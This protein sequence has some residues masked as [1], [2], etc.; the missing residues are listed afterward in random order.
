MSINIDQIYLENFEESKDGIKREK[1][2]NK[3]DH[4]GDTMEISPKKNKIQ[5]FESPITKRK[6]M[7]NNHNPT[8]QGDTMNSPQKKDKS[9]NVSPFHKDLDP[10][11]NKNHRYTIEE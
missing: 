11:N 10:F 9:E 2:F 1:Q 4:C 5:F 6:E 8:A 3:V 7:A